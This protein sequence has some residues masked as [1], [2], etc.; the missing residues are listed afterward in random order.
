MIAVPMALFAKWADVSPGT[1]ARGR[2][3]SRS[4]AFG[5]DQE[6]VVEGV[7]ALPV[8]AGALSLDAP[9][10]DPHEHVNAV[11]GP[12]RRNP[13]IKPQDTAVWRRSY[14]RAARGQSIRWQI[15]TGSRGD[16][17]LVV[18]SYARAYPFFPPAQGAAIVVST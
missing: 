16:H 3:R 17:V 13:G 8:G 12:L 14:G 11:P 2:P 10:V 9:G 15:A 7:G 4:R 5:M 6:S 1:P 18:S